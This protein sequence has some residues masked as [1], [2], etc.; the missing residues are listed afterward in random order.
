MSDRLDTTWI[1]IFDNGVG[2]I[3]IVVS[4]IAILEL[5]FSFVY[6]L[7]VLLIGLFVMGV[8]WVI[9]GIYVL[10]AYLYVRIFMLING[11][12]AIAIV[13][14][15]F[16]FI[17]LP[18]DYLILYPTIAMLLIGSSRLVLGYFI[19][20]IPFWIR[21]LQALAGILTINLA[22]LVFVFPGVAFEGIILLLVIAFIANGLVRLV[23]GLTETKQRIMES[24]VDEDISS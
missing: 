6:A 19:S 9:M 7:E 16:T 13:I 14:I 24:S 21:M 10:H 12:A 4:I 1:S 11:F 22:V 5:A 15:D 20:E 2:L 18:P 8:A 3:V 23:M 17:S